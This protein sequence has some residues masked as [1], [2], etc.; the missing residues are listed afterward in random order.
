MNIIIY[1]FI[2]SKYLR[3]DLLYSKCLNFHHFFNKKVN[4]I[5]KGIID[6]IF[7]YYFNKSVDNLPSNLQNLTFGVFFNQPVNNLPQTLQNLSFGYKFNQSVDNLPQTVLNLTFGW[8]FNQSLD[9]LPNFIETIK[10]VECFNI[11]SCTYN[12]QLNCLPNTISELILPN[13]YN[14]EIKKIPLGLIKNNSFNKS[15]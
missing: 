3:R 14:Y 8:M 2:N 4:N 15:N 6:I 11:Y 9:N 7:G 12:K 13:N 1:R 10:F 5:P